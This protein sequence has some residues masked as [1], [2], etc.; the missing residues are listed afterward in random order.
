MKG[1]FEETAL[2]QVGEL[3]ARTVAE[4]E[5]AENIFLSGEILLNAG[6]GN[7]GSGQ[8]NA[9]DRAL[10]ETRQV[11]WATWFSVC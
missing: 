10:R 1:Q 11:W 4:E 2:G 8:F 5:L 9:G 3:R 6:R 7:T